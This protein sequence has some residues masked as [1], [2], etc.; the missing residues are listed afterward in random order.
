MTLREA[1]EEDKAK[2][3]T[4]V[5]FDI[6]D[7]L[8]DPTKCH[9]HV[10]RAVLEDASKRTGQKVEE[11][12]RRYETLR[13]ADCPLTLEYFDLNAKFRAIGSVLRYEEL[14]ENYSHL[15]KVYQDVK[16]TLKGLRGRYGLSA[17]SNGFFDFQR[18]K[19]ESLHLRQYFDA[20]ITADMCKAVKPSPTFFRFTSKTLNIQPE[21]ILFVDDIEDVAFQAKLWG[22]RAIWINRGGKGNI[23][24]VD[25]VI[26][27]L[28]EIL[29]V[30]QQ[31]S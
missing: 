20:I 18:T 2:V 9:A 10:M 12:R 21:N 22:F 19:L 28:S 29:H 25:F 27:D 11:V 8:I 17:V 30:I 24:K 16:P 15:L 3:I 26:T 1:H 5:C 14:L 23:K 13:A 7:T 4:A 31:I 6:D